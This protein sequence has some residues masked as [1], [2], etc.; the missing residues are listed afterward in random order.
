MSK[1]RRNER[2]G[3]LVK[4]LCDNPNKI[5]T[6]NYFT[7]MFNAAKSTVSED[8]VIIKKIMEN[9]NLGRVET[10]PGAS[11]G[12]RYTTFINVD[13]T[14]EILLDICKVMKDQNRIIPG[15]FLYMSDIIY[16]PKYVRKM[17]EIFATKFAG[18]NIDCVVTVETKGIPL[19]LMT[20][21]VLNIPLVIIRSNNRVTEGS[22]VS[23]NYVSGSTGKIQTM[24][25]SKR[26]IKNGS[27]VLI[28]DD[29]MRA[30]G[31]ARG[32][33]ELMKEFDAKVKG[34]GV[35]ISTKE[36]EKKLVDDYLS[37]I[38]LDSVDVERGIEIYPNE[39]VFK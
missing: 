15:S 5:F 22:T 39:K 19:A 32:I 1:Y 17:G 12:V 4:I 2:I 29:F 35:M 24:Y 27:N 11:G 14:R 8:I 28:I 7:N 18:Q 6:L 20:A 13:D 37:L 21:N 31:T 16:N 25:V 26:A 30:G 36:P 34:I 3:A 9:L 38:I 23:I 10:I 33:V